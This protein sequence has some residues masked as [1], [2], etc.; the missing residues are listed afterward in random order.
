MSEVNQQ[1]IADHLGLSRATVSRC[2]T[3]HAGISPVTRAKVFQTAAEIGYTH[4][5]TRAPSSKKSKK[6]V[7]FSV[8]ICSDTEEYFRGGYESPGEQILAGVSEYAQSHGARVDVNLIPP[9]VEDLDDPAFG[10]V[11]G[12]VRREASGVLL[13]YP[14]PEKVIDQLALRFPLVSLVDQLEHTSIDCVDVDHYYGISSVVDH[15]VA[16]GHERIGFYT[17]DYQV[18]ASWSYRRYSAFIEKMARLRIKTS[19]KDVIGMFPRGSTSLEQSIDEAAERSK[20]GVTAWVCAADHQA[21]DLIQGLKKRDL[22]VPKDV[23]VTGFDGIERVG[24][25]PALTT[26]QIPFR[27]IGITGAERLAARLRKRFHGKQHVYISGKLRA[28]KTVASPSS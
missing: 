4:M 23:S 27:E 28:G 22:K 16:A 2:F 18:E 26:V 6:P 9:D 12:L 1:T 20:Q 3:N 8:L 7:R 10:K 11:E 25:N 19:P 24:R 15:L 5:E 13:I 17:K 21:Y 14:F